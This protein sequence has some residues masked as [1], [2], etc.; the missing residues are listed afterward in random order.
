LETS[1]HGG[2]A[3]G[4]VPD[5]Q[6]DP[7]ACPLVQ[8]QAGHGAG[9]PAARTLAAGFGLHVAGHSP[10]QFALQDDFVGRRQ[11][12]RYAGNGTHFVRPVLAGLSVAAA[13]CLL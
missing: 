4:P 1:D 3:V 9:N 13:D 6:A 8:L 11:P 12:L 7:F 2:G 10:I 5:E